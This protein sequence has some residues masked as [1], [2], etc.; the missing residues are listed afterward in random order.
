M[1][2]YRSYSPD[3]AFLLPPSLGELIAEDDPV[4]FLREVLERLDLDAFHRAYQAERGQPPYHPAL[5]V[6]LFL[7]GAMRGTYSSRRL[8]ELCRRDVA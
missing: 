6:G 1:R 3:Q 5:M 8:A 2:P 4:F 7:Y